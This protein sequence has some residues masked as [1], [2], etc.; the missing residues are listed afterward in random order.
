[1]R[2]FLC[3]LS[4]AVILGIAALPAAAS[5]LI[6][7]TLDPPSGAISGLPGD[8]I[9]WGITITTDTPCWLAIDSVTWDT[10]PYTGV[11]TSIGAFTDF[12]SPQINTL[13]PLDLSVNGSWSQAFDPVQ[14]LG[15]G[16]YDIGVGFNP[17]DLNPGDMAQSSIDVIYEVD[18]TSANWD[19]NDT[20]VYY[21][22]AQLPVTVTYQ[23]GPDVPEPS[24]VATSLAAL[25]LLGLALRA[26]RVRHLRKLCLKQ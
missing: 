6:A 15:I 14:S 4:V 8:T 9:G 12:L 11:Y 13:T 26:S 7:F 16:S 1:M 25:A 22:R 2:S 21:P 3:A 23:E 17:G 5:P 24:T 18:T 19:I 20:I 10:P